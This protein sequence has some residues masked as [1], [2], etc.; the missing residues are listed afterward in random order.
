MRREWE[1]EDL[2]ASW[3]LLPSDVDMLVNKSGATRLGF[4]LLLKFFEIEARF[5]RFPA[6]IPLLAVN[7]VAQQVRVDPLVWESY[8]W[9]G[10]SVKAHRVQ[11]RKRFNFRECSL[12][13]Q[14]KLIAWLAAEVCPIEQRS[15]QLR[16]A[17]VARCRLD[18]L[19]PP[20]SGQL[21]RIATSGMAAFE[22]SFC[23]QTALRLTTASQGMLEAM[24]RTA[25]RAVGVLA[26]IKADPGRVSLETL[27][28]EVN[29]LRQVK[30]LGLPAALFADVSERVVGAWTARAMRAYPSDLRAAD[31]PVRLT[32]LAALCATRQAEITDALVDLLNSLVLKISTRAERRVEGELLTDLRRVRNKEGLLFAVAGAA[33]ERPDDSVRSVVYPVVGETTLRDLVREAKANQQAFQTRVRKV[34]SGSYTNHYRRMLPQLLAAL[35]FRSHNVA[36]RPVMDALEVL[37]RYAGR[38]GRSKVYDQAESVPLDGV[39]PAAWREAICDEAG[40]VSRIPYELCL[41]SALRDALRR[42]EIWVEGARRHG[43]PDVDLPGDYEDNRDVH[44]A[45]LGQPQDPTEFVA[46][47]RCK[48]T[49]GLDRLDLALARGTT[50]G[51]R[52]GLRNGSSWITVPKLAEPPN[53]AALKAEVSQRWGTV[54]LLDML[55]ETD[56][57]VDFTS[58]FTSVATRER[59]PKADLQRRLLLVLFALG[60]NLGIRA[61][62]NGGDHGETEAALRRIRR[63]FLTRDNLR[64]AI[65]LVVSETFARRDEAWWGTGTACASDSKKFGSWESNLMTEWHNRY[66]GPGVMIY[67]HVESK[68]VCIYSQLKS[69]S[70]SEVAAMI[71]GV[72][73]QLG[74]ADI[75]TNYVDTHGA[76]VVGFAFTYLLGFRLLPRL[77]DIGRQRLY[78]ADPDSRHAHLGPALSRPINFDLITQ[79]YDQLVKYATALRLGTAEAEQVL[80]RFTRGGPKHPAYVALQE[81]GRAVKTAFLCEYLSDETLRHEIHQGLQVVENWNSGNGFFFYGKDSDLTGEDREHQETSMLALHLLQSAA[82]LVNTMLMQAVLNEP[83]WAARMTDEDR[84]AMSPLFW[85]NINPY[86]EIHLD[87]GR[88]LGL[89]TAR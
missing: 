35:T 58:Q 67:W 84:R 39:V 44:Y 53:L 70:S 54:A 29:K 16:D 2:I 27:L 59:I 22:Q 40:R 80:R 49:A 81:L 76:S 87:M 71:Q 14:D 74:D 4:A 10:R 75:Q 55:K 66:G 31:M 26:Q 62:V 64:A 41:L 17:L 61:V 33:L 5:P 46:D 82:V 11:I 32:L 52:I 1:P 88:R 20:T 56:W 47:L 37:R 34:L 68:S 42:R 6:E 13:D 50:G 12:G 38:D 79:Q 89:A 24:I 85:A 7:F 78:Q 63:M 23:S 15:D 19:V 43:D 45:A 65:A 30:A 28:G 69:C 21:D 57:L 18:Q 86:G 9:Q 48:L 60:T 3:T 25:D 83:A 36:Y 8:D 72:L 51:V 73:S 77:K